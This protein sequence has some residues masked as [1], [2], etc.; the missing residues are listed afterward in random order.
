MDTYKNL[1]QLHGTNKVEILNA[2]AKQ[3]QQ[4]KAKY[5]FG[6]KNTWDEYV[7]WRNKYDII[8]QQVTSETLKN[9]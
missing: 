1:E 8:H 5:N 2:V 3:Y 7:F 9:S 4:A 6:D